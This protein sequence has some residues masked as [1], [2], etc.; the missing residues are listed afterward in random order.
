MNND[1]D[2]LRW[3]HSKQSDESTLD[4]MKAAYGTD[5]FPGVLK[6]MRAESE[7]EQ[8]CKAQDA[9]RAAFRAMRIHAPV[10]PLHHAVMLMEQQY[11]DHMA[12]SRER[13]QRVEA[14]R[15]EARLALA[16]ARAAWRKS[17]VNWLH[18]HGQGV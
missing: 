15:D 12:V 9:I 8:R 18:A 11:T 3:M 4:A 7:V 5:G 10:V 6:L 1:L 14:E 13:L 16:N 2:S 17:M